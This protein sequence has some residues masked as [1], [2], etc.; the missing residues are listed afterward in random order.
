MIRRPPRSTLFPYTTLFRSHPGSRLERPPQ[1]HRDGELGE[2]RGQGYVLRPALGHEQHDRGGD[3]G[4]DEERSEHRVRS[5]EHT[6]ELQSRLHL[7]CRLLL[8]KKKIHTESPVLPTISP[9]R[10]LSLCFSSSSSS[11]SSLPPLPRLTLSLAST[12]SM[13]ISAKMYMTSTM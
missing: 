11:A 13:S 9:S 7:V 3:H 4:P 5:E 1:R 6:S 12:T 8:E 10:S 2:A